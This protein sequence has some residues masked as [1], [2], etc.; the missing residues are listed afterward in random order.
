MHH[1]FNSLPP[2]PL[3]PLPT[4]EHAVNIGFLFLLAILISWGACRMFEKLINWA[5]NYEDNEL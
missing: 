2:K 3:V 1:F 4:L 5:F